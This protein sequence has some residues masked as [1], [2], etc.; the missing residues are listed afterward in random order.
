MT[1]LRVSFDGVWPE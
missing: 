1:D